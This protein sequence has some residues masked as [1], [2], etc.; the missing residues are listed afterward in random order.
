[1]ANP[2]LQSHLTLCDDMDCSPQGSSI[3]GIFQARIL[4][5]VAIPSSREC[6]GPRNRTQV[7]SVS[8]IGRR[9]LYHQR[10]LGSPR[11]N[12]ALTLKV[13]FLYRRRWSMS[14]P[15][16]YLWSK[17]VMWQQQGSKVESSPQEWAMNLYK[18][19]TAY[20]VTISTDRKSTSLKWYIR[21]DA[22]HWYLQ[23]IPPKCRRIHLLL[24]C[25]WNILQDRPHLGSQIKPQ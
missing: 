17:Q 18:N 12:A 19:N 1:M 7:S 21:W 4:E 16:A 10:H 9:V 2:S 6:S 13:S 24:K 11:E 14:F 20:L 3:H 25:T 23:N 15:L 8:C 22:S 5:W